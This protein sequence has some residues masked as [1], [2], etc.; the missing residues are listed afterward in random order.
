VPGDG[1]ALAVLVRRE[2]D[3][4]DLLGQLGQLGD[5]LPAVGRHHVEG[6]EPVVD[7]DAEPGPRLLLVA[8]G[9]VG[10]VARQ[11]TDVAQAG[12][13]H[14]TRAEIARDRLGLRR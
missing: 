4:V 12:L 8:R 7:V 6:V 1:L 9:H 5:L 13:D 11:V 14:V 2:E 10:R 3:L